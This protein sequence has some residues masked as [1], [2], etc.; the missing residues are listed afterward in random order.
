VA[1]VVSYLV[2]K[3]KTKGKQAAPATRRWE[4]KYTFWI[5]FASTVIVFYL[6]DLTTAVAFL[7]GIVTAAALTRFCPT[8][9]C[10]SSG[11]RSGWP[12]NGR[13]LLSASSSWR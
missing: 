5:F 10:S 2:R 4:K 3:G 11:N 12:G 8:R 9:A 6:T 13:T 1:G 7:I